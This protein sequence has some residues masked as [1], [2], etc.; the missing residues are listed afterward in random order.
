MEKRGVL[1]WWISPATRLILDSPFVLCC[2]IHNCPV[3]ANVCGC[4]W[5]TGFH[6]A[7]VGW[8]LGAKCSGLGA[9]D[10][11]C[12]SSTA[13]LREEGP[14]LTRCCRDTPRLTF[15]HE[16]STYFSVALLRRLGFCVGVACGV[17]TFDAVQ[18]RA[19]VLSIACCKS[20]SELHHHRAS[21]TFELIDHNVWTYPSKL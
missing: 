3:E 9:H 17:P 8:G 15:I 13:C 19:H 7:E 5:F 6:F 18:I 20:I 16:I 4:R 12:P 11:L 2:Y 1:T 14:F 10:H 21:S